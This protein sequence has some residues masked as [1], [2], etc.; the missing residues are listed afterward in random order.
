[1]YTIAGFSALGMPSR[2]KTLWHYEAACRACERD[3]LIGTVALQSKVKMALD[4]DKRVAGSKG[5]ALVMDIPE[6]ALCKGDRL[7]P[8]PSMLDVA[9]FEDLVP[10]FTCVFWRVSSQT[11]A[12][13]RNPLLSAATGVSLA[14]LGID[15]LH[16]LSLGVF[17]HY[18]AHLIWDL[19]LANVWSIAGPMVHRMEL[20]V[21]SLR[22]ELW[23]WYSQESKHGRNWTR[24]QGITSKMLGVSEDKQ[25][26]LHGSETN[27]FLN[28]ADCLLERYKHLLVDRAQGH[29]RSLDAL[30]TI[31]R[32]IKDSHAGNLQPHEIRMFCDNVLGHMQGIK[33]LGVPCKPKHHMLLEMGARL[34]GSSTTPI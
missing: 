9:G 18:L 12:K 28:F 34:R 23:A 6:L 30:L 29:R 25:L 15:W 20:S 1:M 32:L 33:G 24:V 11:M 21:V 22:A 8:G 17:Q 5:R 16:A 10:P 2:A 27:G 14:S 7:E 3:V 4:Y 19:V 26:K 31:Y 13:H